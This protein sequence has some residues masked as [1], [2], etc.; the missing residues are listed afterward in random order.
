MSEPQSHDRGGVTAPQLLARQHHH[1]GNLNAQAFETWL[2]EHGFASN[3]DGR[4]RATPLGIAV[5][6]D[7]ELHPLGLDD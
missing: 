4:L 6:A 7:L 2:L 1:P 3:G 5:A